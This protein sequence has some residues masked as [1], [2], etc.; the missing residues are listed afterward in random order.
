KSDS[1]FLE[2]SWKTI[3]IGEVSF[4]VVKPCDRC[5]ITTI[6]QSTG[7]RDYL[8]EPLKT[9]AT[10]RHYSRGILFGQNLIPKNTG[11][12]SKNDSV[13]GLELQ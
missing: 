10:F 11:V 8:K 12:I 1:P 5:I 13:H 3:K 9:L 7:Q 2:D 4:D 6:D